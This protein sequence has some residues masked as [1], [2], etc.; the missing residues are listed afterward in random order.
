MTYNF[1]LKKRIIEI[2]K[3]QNAF[4]KAIKTNIGILSL[5]IHGRYNLSKSEK[6]QWAQALDCS[7]DEIFTENEPIIS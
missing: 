6:E 3:T 7:I 5:V 4:A 1:P 2:F